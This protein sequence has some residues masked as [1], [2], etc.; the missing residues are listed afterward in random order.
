MFAVVFAALAFISFILTG[1]CIAAWNRPVTHFG[2]TLT[3]QEA[4]GF[5][6]R[7]L[8]GAILVPLFVVFAAGLFQV[9]V[10][11]DFWVFFPIGGYALGSL[12]IGMWMEK[13]KQEAEAQARQMQLLM[14]RTP[15]P[16]V[17]TI[18]AEQPAASTPSQPFR[19]A[20]WD[21]EEELRR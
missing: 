4:R 12:V 21:D 8:F 11:P 14:P 13:E 5:V 1:F 10:N 3:P 18:E 20:S 19:F 2:Q 16:P 17:R 15:F 9:R 7:G 6:A